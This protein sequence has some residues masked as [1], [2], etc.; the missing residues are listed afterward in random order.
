MLDAWKPVVGITLAYYSPEISNAL[1]NN[2]EFGR[3]CW[4]CYLSKSQLT[5]TT[6]RHHQKL[7]KE[8]HQEDIPESHTCVCAFC[9]QQFFGEDKNG[10]SDT[11]ID[12]DLAED[13]S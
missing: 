6:A 3:K 8:Q 5:N 1:G 4:L 13:N 11:S 2:I 10:Q 9:G 7:R 12:T